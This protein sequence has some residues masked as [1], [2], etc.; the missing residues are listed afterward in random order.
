MNLLLLD[1]DNTLYDLFLLF[2]MFFH[3][4]QSSALP[5]R[6]IA[7]SNASI[8]L[9][10]APLLTALIRGQPLIYFNI[11]LYHIQNNINIIVMKYKKNEKKQKQHLL[12]QPIV[13][14]KVSVKW[15]HK[16]CFS[17]AGKDRCG[18]LTLL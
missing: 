16:G 17:S 18:C 2:H 7:S 10:N 6:P 3:S 9:A 4:I 14:D 11:I 12:W 1:N 15:S 13:S 8:T 5:C